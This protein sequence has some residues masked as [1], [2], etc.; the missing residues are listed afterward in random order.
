MQEPG[1]LYRVNLVVGD[2]LSAA[3]K[4]DVEE[5]LPGKRHFREVTSMSHT[6]DVQARLGS[7][8]RPEQGGPQQEV[9]ALNGT[10]VTDRSLIAIL[11]NLQDEEGSVVVPPVLERYGAPSRVGAAG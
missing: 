3:K 8:Y 6:T 5:W 7:R 2:G 10:A 4:H 9:H 1:T 11:E